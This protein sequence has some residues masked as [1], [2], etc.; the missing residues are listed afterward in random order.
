MG[1]AYGKLMG[2]RSL[3]FFCG[4]IPRT[5]SS[6]KSVQNSDPLDSSTLVVDRWK[7]HAHM[8]GK[9]AINQLLDFF[10]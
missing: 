3:D 5:C 1:P 6:P 8:S 9:P 10:V 2:P 4:E 7:P